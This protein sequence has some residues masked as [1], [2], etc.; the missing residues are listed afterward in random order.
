MHDERVALCS[1][2]ALHGPVS[3]VFCLH[4]L[5]ARG[6]Q[7]ASQMHHGDVAKRLTWL[8]LAG[9]SVDVERQLCR[10]VRR[11]S[12][13]EAAVGLCWR[14]PDRRAEIVT[15]VDRP[16]EKHDDLELVDPGARSTGAPR[17]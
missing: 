6:L 15:A 1:T 7:E 8:A 16:E 12:G 2:P 13:S 3:S 10:L 17:T 11:P 5:A 14:S 4:P 9:Q